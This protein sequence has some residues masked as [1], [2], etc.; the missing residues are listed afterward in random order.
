MDSGEVA[1]DK[2]YSLAPLTVIFNKEAIGDAER[3]RAE[4]A[5]YKMDLRVRQC[6]KA[7]VVSLCGC[8]W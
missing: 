2:S 8:D 4:L 1:A 3:Q 5:K 6:S 7:P